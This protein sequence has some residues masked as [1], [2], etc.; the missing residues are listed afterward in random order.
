MKR[1]MLLTIFITLGITLLG[2][3][4]YLAYEGNFYDDMFW[5]SIL[6]IGFPTFLVVSDRHVN[7]NYKVL[8]LFL[9]GSILYIMRILPSTVNFH[10]QDEL[11]T[12]ETTELIY[13]NGTLD[14]QTHFDISRYYP[15]LE[16][17]TIFLKYLTGMEIFPVAKIL[18][19]I[20][21]SMVLVFIFLFLNEIS[22]TRVAAIGTFIYSTNPLYVFFDALFSYESLGIFFVVFL[23][24]MISKN[25]LRNNALLP[26]LVLGAL[27][28]THHLSSFMFLL[29]ILLLII[30]KNY[31]GLRQYTLNIDYL[32]FLSVVLIFGWM[33]YVATVVIN[34]L[35]DNFVGRFIKIF[36]LSLFGGEK[37]D[38]F[39][40]T[41]ST[42]VPYYE[43]V[44]DTFLYA[45]MILLL[46]VIGIYI[47][48]K[49][50]KDDNFLKCLTFTLVI[51]GP[52]LFML[53]L[54]LIPTSGSELSQ[55]TWGFLFIGLSFF[56]AITLDRL[57][58]RLYPNDLNDLKNNRYSPNV[59]IGIIVFI[60]IVTI[61]I[62]G[63]SIGNKPVHREPDLLYPSVVSGAGSMTTDVFYSARWFENNFGRY[64]RMAGEKTTSAIFNSYGNQDVERWNSWK[65]FLPETIDNGV[66][67]S[68]RTFRINYLI[69]DNR[70]LKYAAEYRSYFDNSHIY[71]KLYPVYGSSG[72]LPIESID[73]FNNH[74]RFGKFYDN[75]NI[76]IYKIIE[77]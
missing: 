70:I 22:S 21:H 26:I 60:T 1:L 37:R 32:A 9:F 49:Q 62:G 30:I 71:E 39:Q 29:F 19:G 50:K 43:L 65:I 54:G 18:I 16:L 6:F 53:S 35:I 12:Y 56:S 57:L 44:I 38:I 66:L 41:L 55:R 11:F 52:I 47:S 23:L 68:I 59:I 61:I 33:V 8:F 72:L 20:I 75:G 67:S 4:Y 31:N 74:N 24:Y 58:G 77:L 63:V 7:K 36:E 46:A 51:Y 15:G 64:N 69:V 34:Y 27:V 28:I 14:I 76:N 42:S 3:T 73:K 45:P 40:T 48:F 10:F 13:E 2:V 17:L 25:I 5:M